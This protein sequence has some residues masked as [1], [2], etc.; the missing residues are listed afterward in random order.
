MFYLYNIHLIYALNFV[1]QDR[2]LHVKKK[3]VYLNY[4]KTIVLLCYL[5]SLK[6]KCL[7]S[8]NSVGENFLLV[9]EFQQVAT[10][11]QTGS[12]DSTQI[13]IQPGCA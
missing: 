2:S 11:D 1:P 10:Y 4:Y 6:N 12:A 13:I 7:V 5:M 9:S 3:N 8:N